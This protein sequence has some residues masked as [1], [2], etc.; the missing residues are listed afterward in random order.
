MSRI[1][2]LID[3]HCPDGVE[4]KGI[5][6]LVSRTSNVRWQDVP[7]EQFKY[8]D[9]TSVDRKTRKPLT[10]NRRRAARNKLFAKVT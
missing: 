2:G 3:E 5:G 9:L 6:E 1:G 10:A 7:G 4:F 8:I